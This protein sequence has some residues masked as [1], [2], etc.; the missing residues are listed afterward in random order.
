MAERAPGFAILLL[1]GRLF[2]HNLGHH[3][4]TLMLLKNS[5]KKVNQGF[6]CKKL[7][8]MGSFAEVKAKIGQGSLPQAAEWLV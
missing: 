4:K 3:G 6:K 7:D 8:I 1:Q 5:S 2:K